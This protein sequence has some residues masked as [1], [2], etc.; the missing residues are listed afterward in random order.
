MTISTFDVQRFI[1]Q[2]PF[3]S[4]QWVTLALCFLVTFL[5]GF[6]SA[7]V[8]FV[9][10]ALSKAWNVPPPDLKQLLTVG[11]FGLAAGALFAGPLADRVGRKWILIGALI[12]FGMFS[13]ISAYATGLTEL[14]VLRFLTG[15]GLGA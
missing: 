6:D 2:R 8:G 13:L 15:I 10:P 12:I 14:T 5:D 3:S 1:D 11:F 4:F 7:A 9:A